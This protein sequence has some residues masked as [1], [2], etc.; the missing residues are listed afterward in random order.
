MNPTKIAALLLVT[1]AIIFISIVLFID[2]MPD[3]MLAVG[4]FSIV[5]TGALF[6]YLY[7]QRFSK[8][9]RWML[10]V[11]YIVPALTILLIKLLNDYKSAENVSF[12]F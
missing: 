9:K 1:G 6:L 11:F 4:T 7:G 10:L 2:Q 5:A 12:S 3:S 8:T